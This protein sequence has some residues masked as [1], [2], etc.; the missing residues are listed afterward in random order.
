MWRKFFGANARI[1]GV[2]LNPEAKRWEKDGFEIYIGNQAEPEFWNT[3]FKQVDSVD[4][5]LDDGGHTYDQQIVTTEHVL[6]HIN[7]G[8]MLVVEDT[9]TSYMEGF[10]PK[11][12]SY[13]NYVKLL[14]DKLNFR[15]HSLHKRN[16]DARFWS[17]QIFDSFVVFHIAQQFTDLKSEPVDNNRPS[18]F[19]SDFRQSDN[20][21]INFVE[22][23]SR[24][25]SFLKGIGLF[26]NFKKKLNLLL[27]N[28]KFNSKKYFQ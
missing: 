11:K 16:S 9:H 4:V 6:E 12:Y 27:A 2:D 17:I 21:A 19:V 28:R 8:G 24:K 22:S 26:T 15:F 3:F 23:L 7:E 14:I 5:L 10:G 1:I 25:F 13:L 18:P 20:A